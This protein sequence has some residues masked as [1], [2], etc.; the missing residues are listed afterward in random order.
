MEKIASRPAPIVAVSLKMYFGLERT[1]GYC[2]ELAGKSRIVQAMSSGQ[3]RAAVFPSFVAIP[4]V[5][6][7]LEGTGILVGAQDVAD[8]AI[9]PFTGEVSAQD[10]VDAGCSVVEI[11]HAERR[12]I[13]GETSTMIASKVRQAMAVRLIPLLCIGEAEISTPSQAAATCV[14]QVRDTVPAGTKSEFWLAYEP[15]WAIGASKPA[16]A[17]Y[18]SQVCEA[19]RSSLASEFEDFS[20]LYGGS[21]G[22]GLATTLRNSVDGLFLGRFAH[23]P[24]AFLSVVGEYNRL[25][26]G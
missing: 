18:V 4:D 26:S 9:G 16:P 1:R 6:Q 22:P 15:F 24:E 14:A 25:R 20:I 12:T 8:H 17:D 2:R 19:L 13:Y 23:D 7:I 5:S 3:V 21:A 11:G 10:L